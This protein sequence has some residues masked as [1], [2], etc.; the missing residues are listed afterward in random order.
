M[1]QMLTHS[2][3]TDAAAT[4]T[5]VTRSWTG[6]SLGIPRYSPRMMILALHFV[7]KGTLTGADRNS[8]NE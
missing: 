8:I 6:V 7:L 5:A 4:S 3:A 1:T 2:I